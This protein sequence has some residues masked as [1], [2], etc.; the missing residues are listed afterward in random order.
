MYTRTDKQPLQQVG[1]SLKKKV[2]FK[3]MTD[4]NNNF[5]Q[6]V[7]N[8]EHDDE[9]GE[10]EGGNIISGEPILIKDDRLMCQICNRLFNIENHSKHM[11][12]C[13][14][15]FMSRRQPFDSKY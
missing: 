7:V 15:V 4:E 12:L 10:G 5:V 11:N 3:R 2:K 6:L 14:K 1:I 13:Q 8:T 9:E